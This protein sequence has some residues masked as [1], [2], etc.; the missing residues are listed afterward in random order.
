MWLHLLEGPKSF[1]TSLFPECVVVAIIEIAD[2]L[3][4]ILS[5]PG[6]FKKLLSAANS[7]GAEAK[8]LHSQHMFSKW[9]GDRQNNFREVSSQII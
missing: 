2:I 1:G 6:D 3:K 4:L 9:K 5:F 7:S 8:S